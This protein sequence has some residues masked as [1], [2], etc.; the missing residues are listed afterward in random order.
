MDEFQVMERQ[1][2]LRMLRLDQSKQVVNL[3]YSRAMTLNVWSWLSYMTLVVSHEQ[4][5][6]NA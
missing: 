1:E 6:G 2:R 5:R 4:E 3:W